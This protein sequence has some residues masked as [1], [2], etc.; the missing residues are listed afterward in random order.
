MGAGHISAAPAPGSDDQAVAH[1]AVRGAWSIF[2]R[3]ATVRERSDRTVYLDLHFTAGES[4]L[5]L[6]QICFSKAGPTVAASGDQGCSG[7][8]VVIDAAGWATGRRANVRLSDSHRGIRASDTCHLFGALLRAPAA[9]KP[10][11]DP[12]SV[13]DRLPSDREMVRGVRDGRPVVAGLAGGDEG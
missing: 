8:V 3:A 4:D 2:Q 12:A 10:F 9:P 6:V 5:I 13:I 1:I 7:A 11:S